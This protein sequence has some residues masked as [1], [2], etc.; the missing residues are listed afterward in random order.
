MKV[1]ISPAKTF[2]DKN[3]P[4]EGPLS[5]GSFPSEASELIGILKGF[6]TQDLTALMDISPALAEVNLRR[7]RNWGFPVVQN[8]QRQ[9]IL[10]FQG[11]VYKS[12]QVDTF[13][14][15]D[16]RFGQET[17][18]ILSGLYGLLKPLDMI[19]P[20]R[21]EMGTKL[22]TRKGSNLYQFWGTKI[23]EKLGGELRE[24]EELVNL[25]SHEYVKV[26]NLDSFD[27]VITPIFKDEKNGKVKVIS[28]YAKKARG[29]MC[30]YIVQNRI[31]DVNELRHF[32]LDGYKFEASLS[33]PT[34][35]VFVR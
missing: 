33:N 8:E 27:N 9:A 25:A 31:K 32:S 6:S 19:S 1:I 24:A 26:L 13:D 34:E 21:L 14:E 7:F 17:I 18:R 2:S 35:F 3:G 29:K 22:A 11:D 20:Y 5:A 12:M 15:E 10:A 16:L 30:R 4:A 23:T 28:F